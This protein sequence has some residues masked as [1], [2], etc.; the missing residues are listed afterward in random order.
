MTHALKTWT[1]FYKSIESGEK[2]FEVR[3]ADR[4]F[5][6]GDDLLLQEWN[7]KDNCYT[8]KECKLRIVYIL[9]GGQFGIQDGYCVM[10]LKDGEDY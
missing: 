6:V 10:G 9:S 1:E 2:R 4:P 5:R 3:K 8:G 7:N